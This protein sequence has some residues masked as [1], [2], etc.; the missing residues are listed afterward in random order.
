LVPKEKYRTLL[1]MIHRHKI[2]DSSLPNFLVEGICHFA[3][4]DKPVLKI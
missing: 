2:A 4:P 3:N 1:I